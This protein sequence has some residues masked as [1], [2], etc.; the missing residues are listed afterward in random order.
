PGGGPGFRA[1]PCRA[2]F[3]GGSCWSCFPG[4]RG[5]W[6]GGDW[7]PAGG[8]TTR[9]RRARG[10][11]LRRP[12]PARPLRGARRAAP[13][14]AVGRSDARRSR[15]PH[16][17]Q[18]RAV[19][20]GNRRDGEVARAAA[21]R[22]RGDRGGESVL[23]L[24]ARQG[25]AVVRRP[26]KKPRMKRISPAIKATWMRPVVTLNARPSTQTTISSAPRNQSMT[27]TSSTEGV[28]ERLS[29]LGRCRTVGAA[30]PPT[31]RG[32]TARAAS[33]QIDAL[34]RVVG[35][36]GQ[37]IVV[38]LQ[39]HGVAGGVVI[40]LQDPPGDRLAAGEVQRH[41]PKLVRERL[42][43]ERTRAGG[44]DAERGGLAVELVGGAQARGDNPGHVPEECRGDVRPLALHLR[45]ALPREHEELALL[46]GP[47]GGAPPGAVDEAHLADDVARSER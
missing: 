42:Q 36:D 26:R 3:F 6:V 40:H 45:E 14:H 37:L 13:R 4:W 28:P 32:W 47:R 15:R 1:R 22:S 10:A 21:R 16:P 33:R 39:D 43:V 31:A 44:L 20:L 11:A 29:R 19:R 41:R 38:Q 18:R 30:L 24:Y 35:D 25:V 27:D 23:P 5:G 7:L 34:D 46:G 9:L 12:C 17:V 2:G 8:L